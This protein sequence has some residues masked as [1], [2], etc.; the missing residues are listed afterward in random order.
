MKRLY[1]NVPTS[2][3]SIHPEGG[4]IY[5]NPKQGSVVDAVWGREGAAAE[6]RGGG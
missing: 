1:S 5:G 4:D 2:A 6:E 3:M